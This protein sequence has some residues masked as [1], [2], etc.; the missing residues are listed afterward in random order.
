MALDM[1]HTINSGSAELNKFEENL[2]KLQIH[3]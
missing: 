1:P 3:A 2:K